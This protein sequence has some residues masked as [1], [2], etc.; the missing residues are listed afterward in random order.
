MPASRARRKRALGEGKRLVEASG[1]VVGEGVLSEEC[2]V[3]AVARLQLLEHGV[4][5]IREVL[6]ARAAASEKVQAVG[7]AHHHGVA[8]ELVQVLKSNGEGLGAVAVDEESDAFDVLLLAA[9]CASHKLLRLGYACLGFC[10]RAAEHLH[11]AQPGVG[12][13]KAFVRIYRLLKEL[14]R[15]VALFEQNVN[16]FDIMLGGRR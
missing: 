14:L 1:L 13:R 4:K 8:R 6:H 7:D 16:A 2:P 9:G 15:A 10:R 5:L 12:Q 3:V 11:H